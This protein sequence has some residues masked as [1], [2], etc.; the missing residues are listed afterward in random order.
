MDN[1][2][3]R[4][5]TYSIHKLVAFLSGVAPVRPVIEL[6]EHD[7][8]GRRV[9]HEYKINMFLSHGIER[10]H[11]PGTASNHQQVGKAHLWTDMKSVVDRD[12]QGRKERAFSGSQRSRRRVGL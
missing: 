3:A 4:F 9:I 11:I 5:A 8:V 6:D 12:S 1:L 7:D 2:E 10:F